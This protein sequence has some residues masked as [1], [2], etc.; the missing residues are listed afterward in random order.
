MKKGTRRIVAGLLIAVGAVLMVMA[1]ETWG[2]LLLIVVGVAVE[3]AGIALEK[4]G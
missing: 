4:R 1:P 2:G 3:V